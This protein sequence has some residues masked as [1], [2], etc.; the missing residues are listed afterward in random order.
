MIDAEKLRVFLYKN[1]PKGMSAVENEMTIQA[2]AI[3]LFKYL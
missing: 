3:N 1:S 2:K